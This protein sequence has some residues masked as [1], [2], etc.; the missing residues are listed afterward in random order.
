MVNFPVVEQYAPGGRILPA[1]SGDKL[2]RH[3]LLLL[4]ALFLSFIHIVA[5]GVADSTLPELSL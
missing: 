1:S 2:Y 4:Y 3:L 5:A